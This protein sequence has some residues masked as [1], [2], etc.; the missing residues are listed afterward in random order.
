MRALSL[1]THPLYT[2]GIHPAARFPRDRYQ[3][4]TAH[5][6]ELGSNLIE[7]K[8]APLASQQV[9]ERVHDPLYVSRFLSGEMSEKECRKIG[10]RPWTPLLIPRTLH[11]MGGALAALQDVMQWGGFAANLAGGTHHAHRDWGS[12][13]CVFNDLALCAKIALEDHAL[14]RLAILDLDV[15]Q[16][17][18]TA[19]ILSDT[20]AAFTCSIHCEA[21]FPFQKQKSDLD[22]PLAVAA[23]DEE[24]LDAVD[25]ALKAI[26]QFMPSL[27]L[28]QAGVDALAS[29]TLGRLNVTQIG[30]KER[31]DRVLSFCLTHKIP[32]VIFMGGG[33]S[34][35]IEESVQ[36]FAN[37][38]TATARAHQSWRA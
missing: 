3:K 9:I 32:C 30:M 24:Y 38:F 28:F 17:D 22:I 2:E 37:L 33:Y 6:A 20:S 34:H 1:Y 31:N 23:G 26:A 35:P 5:L 36:A 21:N 12:G 14:S 19:T 16:G 18:G 11:I 29:D 7:L 13:F 25:Q 10:L 27:L 8:Q 4:I 15:H